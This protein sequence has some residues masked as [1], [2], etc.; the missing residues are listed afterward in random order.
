MTNKKITDFD[1]YNY[2]HIKILEWDGEY[3]YNS[4]KWNKTYKNIIWHTKVVRSL[5]A[6]QQSRGLHPGDSN[7]QLRNDMN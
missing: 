1:L 7:M 2:Q 6:K 3:I 4:I 5:H